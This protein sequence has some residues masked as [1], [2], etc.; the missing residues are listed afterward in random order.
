[1]NEKPRSRMRS[2]PG[3]AAT[4]VPALSSCSTRT[5][6]VLHA[7]PRTTEERRGDCVNATSIASF[8]GSSNG[9]YVA[10]LSWPPAQRPAVEAVPPV[11]AHGAP[12]Y[13]EATVIGAS[14]LASAGVE[15]LTLGVVP[16][17]LP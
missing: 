15:K 13:T 10:S 8:A 11:S 1:M 16:I 9:R 14:V 12:G 4:Q 5:A 2:E 6:P 7:V 17:V 3:T